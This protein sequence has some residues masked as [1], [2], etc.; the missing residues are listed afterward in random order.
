IGVEALVRWLPP[1]GGMVPPAA[2]IPLAE[3][4]GLIRPITDW[5]DREI[6]AQTLEWER[7]GVALRI[8]FQLPDGAVGVVACSKP[9]CPG[10]PRRSPARPARAGGDRVGGHGRSR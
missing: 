1:G 7:Q 2:F 10:A 5:I 8:S 6:W 3:R 9:A 4:T